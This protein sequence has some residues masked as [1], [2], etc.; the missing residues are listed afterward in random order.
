M[1]PSIDP[2]I[3]SPHKPRLITVRIFIFNADTVC[4]PVSVVCIEPLTNKR[5]TG[6]TPRVHNSVEGL[7]LDLDRMKQHRR[8][9]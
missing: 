9:D 5:L 8:V 4:A 6:Y 7:R 1:G 3:H 2:S